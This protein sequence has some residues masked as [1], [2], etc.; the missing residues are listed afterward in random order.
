[1][2]DTDV[3]IVGGGISGLATAW[4]LSRAGISTMLWEQQAR[5]GGKII[6]DHIDGYLVEQGATMV[7]NFH[8]EVDQFITATGLD[9]LKIRR[10]ALA[11]EKRY[12]MQRGRLVTVPTQLGR[13]PFTSAWSLQGKLRMLLE[14]LIKKGGSEIETVSE[15]IRRRLGNEL[16]ETAIEPF[17]SGILASDPDRANAYTAIPRLTALEQR[18]GSIFKGIIA[19]KLRRRRTAMKSEVFSFQGGM[20]A[21]IKRLSDTLRMTANT[22]FQSLYSVTGAQR[23]DGVWVIHADSPT[24][25]QTITAGQLVLCTPAS[26][27]ASLLRESDAELS[28]LLAGIKYAGM[29]VV[30]LGFDLANI[31]HP[32]NGSGFLV[33]RGEALTINGNLW[34]SAIFP[35]RAPSGKA[36]LTT[37]LGGS[38]HPDA[39]DWSDTRSVDAVLGDIRSVL[40]IRGEP[41]M[42]R[43]HRDRRALPLYHGSYFRR[44]S[45]IKKRLEQFPG[46]HLQANYLGGISVRDRLVT[47]KATATQIMAQLGLVNDQDS[48]D[49]G[50]LHTKVLASNPTL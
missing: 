46:L 5:P 41:E 7:M 6:S 14:P 42:V 23:N 4:W 15:F 32:L 29:A 38:R 19:N 18:Y 40:G 47:S 27:S 1:M 36:L 25:S 28:Y 2:T 21:L 22:G 11:E 10:D 33:P 13:I 20:S 43:V 26:V 34:M 39:L 45:A 35:N 9:A 37:Y 31:G 16:L 30:H 17:I 44:C 8:P 24:G 48:M 12:L 50:A 49:P 3:L